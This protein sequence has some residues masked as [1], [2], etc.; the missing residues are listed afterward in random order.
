MDIIDIDDLILITS[1]DIRGISNL[2]QLDRIFASIDY[3]A[4]YDDSGEGEKHA[5]VLNKLENELMAK[6]VLKKHKSSIH[7]YLSKTHDDF[8]YDKIS[9]EE[10]LKR[11]RKY[12]PIALNN[13][14]WIVAECLYEVGRHLDISNHEL[15]AYAS[16]PSGN[17]KET[18]VEYFWGEGYKLTQND[19][20][21]F[22]RYFSPLRKE[23]ERQGVTKI[24]Y[25]CV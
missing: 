23:L 2:V 21:E 11:F 20:E 12:L 25:C 15:L 7:K 18:D 5:D 24:Q 8:C 13:G 9:S 22:E 6:L 3:W 14:C 4:H 1:E 10:Y 17:I 19:K 16:I